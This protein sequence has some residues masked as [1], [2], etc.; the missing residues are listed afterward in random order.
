MESSSCIESVSNGLHRR[1]NRF[2]Q[3]QRH[4]RF[5]P[6][7]RYLCGPHR[8][9]SLQL[10]RNAK[11]SPGRGLRR[12]VRSNCSWQWFKSSVVS[13]PSSFLSASAIV[14]GEREQGEERGMGRCVSF[15]IN[16]ESDRN[17]VGVRRHRKFHDGRTAKRG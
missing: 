9:G 6:P 12:L 15:I 13:N 7:L 2:I 3:D 17:P 4:G 10:A 16:C 5:C 11:D 1:E 14:S 8:R